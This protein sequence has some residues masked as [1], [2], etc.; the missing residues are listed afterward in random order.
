MISSKSKSCG[1][2]GLQN[3]FPCMLVSQSSS[4]DVS[5]SPS[6]TTCLKGQYVMGLTCELM[7]DIVG[8]KLMLKI[9]LIYKINNSLKKEFISIFILTI[10]SFPISVHWGTY[11]AASVCGA[12]QCLPIPLC[13]V[14]PQ[15][16]DR[17]WST[18][19]P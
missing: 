6:R 3:L 12:A 2:S 4:V 8:N 15:A 10:Y 17:T 18:R 1:G 13:G 16:P 5:H 9:K 14:M 19:L 11:N 7:N